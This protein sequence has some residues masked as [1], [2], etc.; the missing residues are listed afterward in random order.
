M[1]EF[2]HASREFP[3]TILVNPCAGGGGARK[4]LQALKQIFSDRS[5]PAEFIQTEN[6]ESLES[7]ARR[8]IET[9]RRMLFALGGDGTVQALVNAACGSNVVLGVLPAGGGNDFA[10]ALGLPKS[11]T[12]ALSMLL[13]GEPRL[14]DVVSARTAEGKRRLYVGGGG[15]GLDA[16]SAR[17][18]ASY[19]WIPGRVRYLAAALRALGEFKTLQV[20][21]EFPGS[22]NAPLTAKV[23]LA[24]VLNSPTYGAGLRL[25]PDAR[26]DDGLLSLV[27]VRELSAT[28]IV[29]ALPELL[30]R[31][32][33]PEKYVMRVSARRLRIVS[34][35]ECLFH[36][37][38]EIFGAAPVEIEVLPKAVRM[39]APVAS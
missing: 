19:G 14:V 20:S 7:S 16:D 37:D 17:Y 12:A 38:G 15:L 3:A 23:L 2:V 22:D 33:L 1:N 11:P 26:I 31:G 24:A 6:A 25:A 8:A 30:R 13:T 35:R 29:G 18:S 27:L 21:V 5:I 32:T 34:D 4:H 39:L 36:G 10:A 9:G 28:Q